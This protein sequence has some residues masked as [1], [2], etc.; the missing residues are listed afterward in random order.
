MEFLHYLESIRTDFGDI[1]FSVCTFIGSQAVLILLFCINF[2]CIDKQLA[3][4]I[5][6]SFFLS[7]LAVQ[8]IKIT[9]RVPRPFVLDPTLTPVETAVE[10]ATGYSF[11]S[12]HTQTS[13]SSLIPAAFAYRNKR[14]LS[15]APYVLIT[16]TAFSRMYL[17]VH[18]PADVGTS[19]LISIACAAA[20]MYSRR[21]CAP[22]KWYICLAAIL[23]VGSVFTFI[24]AGY[25]SAEGIIEYDY[26][27]DCCKSAGSALGFAIGMTV[28][29]RFIG[30]SLKE[31]SF[32][33]Y[34]IRFLCGLAGAGIIY[35]SKLFYSESLLLDVIRYFMLLMW[36]TVFYPFILAKLRGKEE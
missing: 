1:F 24:Y 11:P 23:A 31:N 14:F 36:I 25:L 22:D 16:L 2:W 5:G 7:S 29:R 18:T 35:A 34:A 21:R 33:G 6:G 30:F 28:E 13:A 32:K 27:A 3:A 15:A 4:E 19:L 26:L 12:G 9:L 20:V 17:G 8:D 10:G